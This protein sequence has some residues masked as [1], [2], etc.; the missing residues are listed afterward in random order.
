MSVQSYI[1]PF[2]LHF[3][4]LSGIIK[5]SYRILTTENTLDRDKESCDTRYIHTYIHTYIHGIILPALAGKK[6]I[7]QAHS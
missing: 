2:L 7:N 6:Y 1:K 3:T 4:K 5:A